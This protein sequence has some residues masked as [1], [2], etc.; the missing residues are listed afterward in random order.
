MNRVI[1]RNVEL[2]DLRFVSEIAV[3]GWQTAYR[4][5]IE[6]EFLDNLS[7]EENYLKRLKDYKENGF[8]VAEQ[9]GEVVGFC[10]YKMGKNYQ[11]EYPDVDC[12]L[13]AL[14]VKTE[15][16][17]NG[18]GKA[19]V[20][21]A[22]N[23][24]KK[25]NLNKMIIWCL[26]ENYPS[27]KFYEKIGGIYCGETTRIIGNKEYSEVGYV[28]DLESELEL[29][30]PTKEYKKQVEEYMQEFFDN[31]EFEIAGDGSLDRI[32][33]FDKWLQKVQ[34]DLSEDNIENNRIP[35]TV[36]LTI[37]KTDKKIVGNV[38]IRH[39]L[40]EKQ[41]L[42]GGHI[43]DSVRPSE[44]RKGYATEQIRLALLKCKELGIDRVLMD[45]DK[46]NIGSAKSI[47]KNGGILENEVLINNELVQRYWI[48]LKKRY[49][50]RYIFKNN[51]IYKKK[52]IESDEFTGDICYYKFKSVNKKSY[53]SNGTCIKDKDYEWLEFYDYNSK[54]KLS[55]LYNQN[56]QIIEWYFD[57]SKEIGS[58][59]GVP[60]E[61]DLYLDVVVNPDGEIILLDEDELKEALYRLEI[62]KEDYDMAY[63]E[64]NM[65][66]SKLKGNKGKLEDFTNKYLDEMRGE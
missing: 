39:K 17:R 60:Y 40:N 49:A 51:T 26:K 34:N 63:N 64:A 27:R 35:S 52:S 11:V 2:K 3:R 50:N 53:I 45:C 25:A 30:F 55:A 47:I 21:Y 44:R 43:G 32:K 4:G 18:I 41:L 24:F 23:E 28:Y 48:S 14:Y 8:I 12:E 54:V 10:R 6:D 22:K 57:I 56:K 7:I 58:E 15:E 37:R 42:Y 13:C 46:N 38:Q 19:L 31:G 66:T 5:I 29:V 1:I 62:S 16:K 61:D 20:N 9:D 36:Y 59:N 65:L 33:D